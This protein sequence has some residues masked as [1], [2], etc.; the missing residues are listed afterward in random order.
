L[1]HK[2]QNLVESVVVLKI[3]NIPFTIPPKQSIEVHFTKH[4][5][6]QFPKKIVE[7]TELKPESEAE[8]KK[9]AEIKAK[10]EADKK[11]KAEADKKDEADKKAK[12]TRSRKT[13]D[14]KIETEENS[15]KK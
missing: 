5:K 7:I 6:L 13:K 10:A 3:D 4:S 11:A 12:T 9:E 2:V 1:T 14:V 8:A 15:V